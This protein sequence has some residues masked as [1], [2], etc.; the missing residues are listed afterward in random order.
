MHDICFAI[1]YPIS[2]PSHTLHVTQI[3]IRI[4]T[5]LLKIPPNARTDPTSCRVPARIAPKKNVTRY[6]PFHVRAPLF[7]PA[8]SVSKTPH[9][10]ALRRR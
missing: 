10:L 5:R 3:P 7:S 9:A 2:I 8:C 1:A 6:Y 4:K